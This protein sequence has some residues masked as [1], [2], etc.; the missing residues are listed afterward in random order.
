MSQQIIP[1]RSVST[2]CARSRQPPEFA[3]HCV[4]IPCAGTK[5]VK[6]RGMPKDICRLGLMTVLIHA[7]AHAAVTVSPSLVIAVIITRNL[8]GNTGGAVCFTAGVCFVNVTAGLAVSVGL[9]V[10]AAKRTIA[11]YRRN[12]I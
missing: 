6:Q 7:A 8:T 2:L 5:A 9:G 10:R 3:A 1:S 12:V 11:P 4:D